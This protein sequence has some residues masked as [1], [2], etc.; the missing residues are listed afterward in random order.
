MVMMLKESFLGL[1]TTYD[2]YTSGDTF[3]AWWDS[4][5]GGDN[6]NCEGKCHVE[7][8][9]L[10]TI[11]ITMQLKTS[12]VTEAYDASIDVGDKLEVFFWYIDITGYY[13]GA[14]TDDT[15][16]DYGIL[17]VGGSPPTSGLSVTPTALLLS[18]LAVNFIAIFIAKKKKK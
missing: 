11:E 17:N 8:G 4:N 14:K 5:V 9:S 2:C 6:L 1:N 18:I 12:D 7:S 13:S 3:N 15:D 10:V 16:Y